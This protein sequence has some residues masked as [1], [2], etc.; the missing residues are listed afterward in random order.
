MIKTKAIILKSADS[1]E[2]DRLLTVYSEKLGKIN[3]SAKGVKKLESKL[4]YSIEP[5]TYTQMIL[6]EGKNFLI[7]KDSVILEQFL[8]TK[9]NPEKI[10]IAQKLAELIDEAI[11]GEE[12]DENIWKLALFM[13]K[14]IEEDKISTKSAIADFQ[15]NL[16]K[17]L[18]Y[19]PQDI[20]NLNEIY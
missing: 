7:L 5:I 20:K 4:R 1:N 6:V 9:K 16:I 17:L 13:F 11:I 14:S 10:K 8:K 3:I 12:K 19:S 2:V 18:G 15:K